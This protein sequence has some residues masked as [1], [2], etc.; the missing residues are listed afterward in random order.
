MAVRSRIDEH[1]SLGQLLRDLSTDSVM[2]LRQEIDL[3]KT[4]IGEKIGEVGTMGRKV[5]IGGGL[6]VAGGLALVAAL[7][8]G[9]TSLLSEV[10]SV[11]AAMWL[12]PLIVGLILAG[13][14]YALIRKSF[15]A[16]RQGLVP[17]NTAK[18]LQENKE[19][20]KSRIR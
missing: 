14:G 2:L 10:M 8:L 15:D 13:V 16:H 12:A 11:W 5:A 6:A 4:E 9:L 19:W 7:I 1:R 18:S 20:L 17:L 3:A